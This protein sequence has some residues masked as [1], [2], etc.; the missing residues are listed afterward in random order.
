[1]GKN[2]FRIVNEFGIVTLFALYREH[3]F[4]KLR[5]P[6]TFLIQTLNLTDDRNSQDMVKKKLNCVIFQITRESMRKTA[7]EKNEMNKRK[8]PF[9][10]STRIQFRSNC[11]HEIKNE[12]KL[13][14]VTVQ[15]RLTKA[16]SAAVMATAF[17]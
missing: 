13:G 2:L 10:Y 7:I 14:K 6:K 1:M 9:F 17:C 3:R 8:S 15:L 16:E 5:K 11:Y 4:W 12:K